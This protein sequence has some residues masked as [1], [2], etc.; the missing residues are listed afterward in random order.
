MSE[1]LGVFAVVSVALGV[2]LIVQ[3]DATI[4]RRGSLAAA[5][6]SGARAHGLRARRRH[7]R[8]GNTVLFLLGSVLTLLVIATM[9]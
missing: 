1:L 5:T 4:T 6:A 3:L 8:K 9:A 2:A 7:E